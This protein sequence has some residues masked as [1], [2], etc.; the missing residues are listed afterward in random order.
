MANLYELDCF[1]EQAGNR[2]R[3]YLSI[4]EPGFTLSGGDAYC[5][6]HAPTLFLKDKD[7]YGADEEQ[8]KELAYQFVRTF[9]RG[10]R[11]VDATGRTIGSD[12]W[13]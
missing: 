3:F 13:P 12:Q 8:A 9:L 7:I 2:E 11:L 1:I 5:R 6:V 10:K 4:S